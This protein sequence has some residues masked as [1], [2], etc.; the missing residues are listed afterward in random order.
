LN[1][2]SVEIWRL[3]LVAAIASLVGWI[4]GYFL[5]TLFLA[6]FALL[7]FHLRHLSE[8]ENWLNEGNPNHP[9]DVWGVWGNIYFNVYHLQKRYVARKKKL[10]SIVKQFKQS[11]AAM[12]DGA[13]VLGAGGEIA[14]FNTPASNL[15]GLKSPQDIGQRLV[16]LV[17]DPSFLDYVC[18]EDFCESL[19]LES[20]VNHEL[21]LS[22]KICP[23]GHK[24][25]LLLVRDVTQLQKLERVRTDFVSNIS[26]ELRTP[27]TV[28]KGCVETIEMGEMPQQWKKP[29]ALIA[30]QSLRM[31]QL[32]NDLL[33]L[34]R[35]ESGISV[36]RR[37]AF[38]M[39][40]LIY[41]V[42]EEMS[43]YKQD[44][45]HHFRCEID[46]ELYLAGNENEI[47]SVLTNLL[48][49]AVNYSFDGCDILVRWYG[50]EDGKFF[51]VQDSGDGILPED[52][53]RLTERF[54][55][56]DVARSRKTGGTGLGLAIVHHV[57][58]G[59]QAK[60]SIE[61]MVGE[62]STFRCHFTCKY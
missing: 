12:P 8:L 57:L 44:K 31:E 41:Q 4:V 6:L 62:G 9:P 21:T 52:I 60:L 32:V 30:E 45:G 40:S 5:I 36:E 26:H 18:G 16:N 42:I 14:W 13:V 33:L 28:L 24:Q 43:H 35:V 17:R 59:H 54:F 20:P 49:N 56:V 15:L 2:W 25:R 7:I 55:R 10:A 58:D 50:N 47:R 23:Y 19:E 46:P 39:P 34:S 11:T 38:D 53:P 22:L 27:L 61:S 48:S 1:K 29:M 51:E 37:P 3:I